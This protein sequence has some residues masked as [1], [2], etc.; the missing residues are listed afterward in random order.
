MID[1]DHMLKDRY[2]SAMA[3][4]EG[5]KD[6]PIVLVFERPGRVEVEF[7]SPVSGSTG[8]NLRRLLKI[9]HDDY[10]S[11]DELNVFA[12]EDLMIVNSSP[13]PKYE[14][15]EKDKIPSF[16]RSED[17]AR[18]LIEKIGCKK[19]VVCFGKN[20]EAFYSDFLKQCSGDAIVCCHLSRKGLNS[21]RIDKNITYDS[22]NSDYRK[23]KCMAT[24]IYRS[25]MERMKSKRG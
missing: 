2:F 8:V 13:R 16:R 25:V 17:D 23:L 11:S 7:Q 22:N 5:S 14:G 1:F 19:I 21:A 9:I 20:A 24:K 4:Q 18:K 6:N 10:V 3:Y 12:I 15:Y